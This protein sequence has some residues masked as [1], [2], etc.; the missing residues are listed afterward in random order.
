MK[1]KGVKLENRHTHPKM[2]N[3]DLLEAENPLIHSL[4]G[5][6][7]FEKNKKDARSFFGKAKLKGFTGNLLLVFENDFFFQGKKF[8]PPITDATGWSIGFGICSVF[9]LSGQIQ[10]KK[11]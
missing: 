7:I 2:I 5:W 10:V 6:K 1:R 4:F 9:I 3:S 11:K 8:S